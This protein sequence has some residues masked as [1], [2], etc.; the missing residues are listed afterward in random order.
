MEKTVEIVNG[1]RTVKMTNKHFVSKFATSFSEL[2][3]LPSNPKTGRLKY[4]IKRTLGSVQ[5]AMDRYN[6]ER[7]NIFEERAKMDEHGNPTFDKNKNYLFE[8]K[9]LRKDA[10]K[11]LD[12]LDRK[13]IELTVYPIKA[14][15]IVSG[16]KS[17]S[18]ALELNLEGFI[19]PSEEE[20]ELL[21]ELEKEKS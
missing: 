6:Q 3:E 14:E 5:D 9:D 13:L 2:S 10:F 16:N 11:E 12:K 19:L 1:M 4:A 17:L 7:Q 21:N 15:N 8:T 18:I 20:V